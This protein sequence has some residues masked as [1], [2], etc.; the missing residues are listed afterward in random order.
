MYECE[1]LGMVFIKDSTF[2]YRWY[3]IIN[4]LLL[5]KITNTIGLCIEFVKV[6][7][8]YTSNAFF[9]LLISLIDISISKLGMSKLFFTILQR[10]LNF[11][12]WC[13]TAHCIEVYYQNYIFCITIMLLHSIYKFYLKNIFSI[14]AQDY[15]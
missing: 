14:S 15:V 8:S 1:T 2:F 3:S 12:V 9:S 4:N 6:I 7:I 10:F 5:V 11:T 13:H